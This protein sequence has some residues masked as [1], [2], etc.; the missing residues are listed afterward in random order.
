MKREIDTL[1]VEKKLGEA[2]SHV[3]LLRETSC[4]FL[5]CLEGDKKYV[6]KQSKK[7]DISH[8]F[9][10]H[11]II[12]ECWAKDKENL[13]FKVPQVYFL[14][15]GRDFYL[16][17]YIDGAV[18]LLD[19]L[20]QHHHDRDEIFRRAGVCLRQYHG[21][22]TRYLLE[23][24]KSIFVHNTVEQLLN[25]KSAEKL[26]SWLNEFDEQTYRIIFKDFTFSNLAL[27][28]SGQL[29]FIDFQNIY[30]YAPFYY[31]LARFI[32]TFKVFALVRRPGFS[33]LNRGKIR[34]AL[35]SFVQ[36]YD[37]KLDR[38]QLKTMQQFHR[39]EHIQMKAAKDKFGALVLRLI[40]C[41]R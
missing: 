28:R 35:E 20:F 39:A 36:G 8:E 22:T 12:Y 27:D 41:I 31:D 29:Y 1:F 18:N 11:Q 19:V 23:K 34:S 32:D 4:S 10:N 25:S 24:R 7:A 17:E 21:L 14:S 15:D 40:Y 3:T 16:M 13:D 26:K 2:I 33:L 37:T 5:Y 9:Q 30:Y 38:G 6:L